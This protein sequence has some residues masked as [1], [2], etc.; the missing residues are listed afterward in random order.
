MIKLKL[1]IEFIKIGTF[2][3]GGGFATLPFIQQLVNKTQWIAQNE[4]DKMIT[5]SQMTPG[6]LAVNMATYLGFKV[7]GILRSNYCNN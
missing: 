3:F 2:A 1:F 4:L 5:I 7:E 6:P